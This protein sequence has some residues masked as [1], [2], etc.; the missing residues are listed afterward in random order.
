LASVVLGT[1]WLN[2]A[3]DLADYRSFPHM[4][5]LSVETS[6]PLEVRRMANGRLRTVSRAGSQTRIDVSLSACTRADVSWLESKLGRVM[7]VRDD[8]GRRLWAVFSEFPA[9]EHQYDD[10]ADVSLSFLEVSVVEAV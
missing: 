1:L 5:G 2:D 4:T 3:A 10:E 8:R 6:R 7:L 9:E